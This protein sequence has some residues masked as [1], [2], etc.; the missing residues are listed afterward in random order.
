[1]PSKNVKQ[2]N[3]EKVRRKKTIAIAMIAVIAM[4]LI[5]LSPFGGNI[6]F[7]SKWI[8]CG[9]KPVVGLG[10]GYWNAGVRHYEESS[11]FKLFLRNQTWYCSP[12]EAERAGYSANEDYYRT[13]ALDA[14]GEPNKYDKAFPEN[15]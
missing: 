15:H 11:T 6:R 5:D 8:E 3:R 9:Q 14:A 10:S 13:P 4:I 7:Y 12:I 2:S 1:M